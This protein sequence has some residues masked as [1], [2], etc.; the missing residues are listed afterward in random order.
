MDIQ[1][2]DLPSRVERLTESV[3]ATFAVNCR[4][5]WGRKVVPRDTPVATQLYWIVHE[6][7]TNALRHAKPENISVEAR[8]SAKGARILVRDDGRGL[9]AVPGDAEGI[10][11]HIMRSRARMIRA[12]LRVEPDP[13]G[14]TRVVCDLPAS[15]LGRT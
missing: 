14:G 13:A 2:H 4:C 1:S 9:P 6:A 8:R 15:A 3:R 10:G 12:A 5:R 11:L 7:V